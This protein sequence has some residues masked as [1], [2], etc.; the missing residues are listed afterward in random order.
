MPDRDPG[1]EL[2]AA[3]AASFPASDPPAATAPIAATSATAQIPASDGDGG[4][5]RIYRVIEARQAA[6]PFDGPGSDAGGRWTTPRTPGVYASLSPATAMLEYLAHLEGATP[7]GLLLATASLPRECLLAQLEVPSEWCE[8]PYRASVRHVGDAWSKEQRSLAL[9][10][11]S[12]V[13]PPECNVLVNPAHRDFARLQLQQLAPVKLD[14][15][16]RI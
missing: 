4:E 1:G 7:E 9:R 12:A 10:V 13:C 2:D 14:A 5:V 3:L 6:H 16:L 11:P 8:R 15:R